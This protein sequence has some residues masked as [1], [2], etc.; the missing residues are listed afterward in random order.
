MILVMPID[1]GGCGYY[2]LKQPYQDKAIFLNPGDFEGTDL[3]EK[4]KDNPT[5]I[6]R[7]SHAKAINTLKKYFPGLKIVVD[8]DDD[9]FNVDPYNDSYRYYG[10]KEV[11]HG[12]QWLWKDGDSIDLKRNNIEIA[13][14]QAL[15][16]SADMLTVSTPRLAKHFKHPN[17]Y[18]NYN[19]INFDEWKRV[20]VKR[21]KKEFRL[22][23]SGSPSHYT[24]WAKI[25]D[26]LAE[27]MKR[28][29]DVKLVLAGA[30][31]DGTV[32]NIDPKRIEYW[33]WV[34][35]EAHPYRS[36]LLD[37]DLAIIP[38]ADNV[39]NS[40]KSC[41]KWYEFSALGVPTIASNVAPYSDEMPKE[42]LFDELLPVFDRYYQDEKLREDN[43]NK[44]YIWVK[45][46]RN[47]KEVSQKLW[48]TLPSSET[49]TK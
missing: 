1:N 19:A 28:Y 13:K 15:V 36:V 23:W 12:K 11:K 17:I 6:C 9:I 40:S 37:L 43:A 32:K 49:A 46:N 45:E 7:T 34:H 44:Q 26:E 14:I 18:I 5:I 16:D 22:G 29:P 24:D 48:S 27:L 47:Q 42:Q 20:K 38:L 41:V 33:P 30:M 10:L 8:L 21:E 2:R 31:F 39:F 25:Q 3:P 35:P 4:L